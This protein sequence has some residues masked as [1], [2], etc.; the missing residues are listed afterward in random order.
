MEVPLAKCL[1]RR[2]RGVSEK[3]LGITSA[4]YTKKS[5]LST[6][7]QHVLDVT[8]GRLYLK[9]SFI[10]RELLSWHLRRN[11]HKISIQKFL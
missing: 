5:S 9:T 1:P 10:P 11:D 7:F 2:K 6:L 4:A 3:G 8:A